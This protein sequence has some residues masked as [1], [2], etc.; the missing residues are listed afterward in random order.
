MEKKKKKE[1]Y[2]KPQLKVIEL[3]ADE[4]LAAGC[5]L[6]GGPGGPIVPTCTGTSCMSAGS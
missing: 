3:K 2:E 6:S 4:V 5:K 1:K